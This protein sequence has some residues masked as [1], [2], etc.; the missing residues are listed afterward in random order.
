MSTQAG[1]YQDPTQ[2]GLLRW[3]DGTRWSDHS[4]PA[5]PVVYGGGTDGYAIAALV[6]ALVGVPIVP[7]YLGH[8]ARKRI[9]ES[10][11]L[12]DGDGLAITG[13]VFGYLQVAVLA[14]LLIAVMVNA[15]AQA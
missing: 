2:P 10:G 15:G 9:R 3:W 4:A 7:V 6:T 8:K 11:G 14:I 13:L 1:W 5:A 12:K